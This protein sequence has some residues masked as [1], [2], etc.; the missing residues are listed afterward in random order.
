MFKIKQSA[1]SEKSVN[2]PSKVRL[3]M[4]EIDERY[5]RSKFPKHM[6]KSNCD[7]HQECDFRNNTMLL[8]E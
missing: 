8:S 7:E 2:S 5:T 4:N 6:W 3:D 1:T